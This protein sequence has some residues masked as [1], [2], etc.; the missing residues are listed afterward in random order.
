MNGS[1]NRATAV[2]NAIIEICLI[3]IL[4]FTPLVLGAVR[5][6]ALV[7]AQLLILVM[8]CA[9]L[10]KMNVDGKLF[11]KPTA[12][13]IPVV[14]F[15]FISIASSL[16][17]PYRH[18]AVI[19]LCRVASYCALYFVFVNNMDSRRKLMR[20]VA[21]LVAMGA[22][23]SLIGIILHLNY[24]LCRSWTPG[25]SVSS[26][27]ANR[28]HFA[29]YL[30][31]VIPLGIGLLFTQISKEK[32]TLLI[33]LVIV[34]AVSFVLASSRGAWLSLTLSCF[35][36]LPLFMRKKP[37]K[38]IALVCIICGAVLYFT[39]SQFD[40]GMVTARL[41]SIA[42]GVGIDDTRILI[43]QGAI[44]LIKANPIL[45]YS[46]GMFIHAFPQYR[47]AG[48]NPSYLIDYAHNDYLH[49]ASEIG[50]I[51]LIFISWIICAALWAGFREAYSTSS[52][53]RMGVSA[54]ASI[55]I[56]SMALHS[57]VDFSLHIPANAIV[58]V[59]LLGLVTSA[60]KD[61]SA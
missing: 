41:A 19:A 30:E 14:L 29:G 51:G 38:T 23:L 35:V 8:F 4:V 40:L 58:F 18:D 21:T 42:E 32:K 45:G 20:T 1:L 7:S 15:L 52:T 57:F 26:T 36:M 10:F 44:G 48:I 3:A 24:V 34:M 47:P 9:W 56:M 43:W 61:S 5:P 33:F 60:A 53:F 54:G 6:W 12:L 37:F 11:F 28:D 13:N 49:M 39:L 16:R 55:G 22:L 17:A 2:C 50:L 25:Q 31:M 46:P 27:F 59:V